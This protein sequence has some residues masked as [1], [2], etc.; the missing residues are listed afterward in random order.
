MG[1]RSI[2]E[3]NAVIN[4]AI[5]TNRIA[6]LFS[7]AEIEKYELSENE[8]TIFNRLINFIENLM[9]GASYVYRKRESKIAPEPT[10]IGLRDFRLSRSVFHFLEW[11]TEDE[12]FDN[13]AKTKEYL[14]KIIDSGFISYQEKD[15]ISF[16]KSFFNELSARMHEAMLAIKLSAIDNSSGRLWPRRHLS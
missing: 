14:Q 16:L 9:A 10:F 11:R 7:K 2:S 1:A 5:Q 15:Q 6:N 3:K 8:R 13:L 12:L 4:Y